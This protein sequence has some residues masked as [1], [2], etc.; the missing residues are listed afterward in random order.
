MSPLFT[1]INNSEGFSGSRNNV[2]NRGWGSF[3]SNSPRL[4][5]S[6]NS[7]INGSYN[8]DFERRKSLHRKLRDISDGISRDISK[9]RA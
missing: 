7:D 6:Y 5:G 8:S 2:V 4:N 9:K 1:P 3:Y